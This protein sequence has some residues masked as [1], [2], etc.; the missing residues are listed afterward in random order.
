MTRI[1]G[2]AAI[3]DRFDGLILDQFGVLHDGARAYPD[4]AGCVERLVK[5]G[6]SLVLLS[7]SGRRTRENRARL[8]ALG[9]PVAAFAAVVTSGEVVWETLATRADLFH[10]ALGRRCYLIAE[11]GEALFLAGLDLDPVGTVAD[12][13]F[14][15]LLGID[16]PRRS[17]ADYRPALAAGV[18][19]GIPLLCANSDLVRLTRSGL[20]PASGA[21]A[22]KYAAMGGYVRWYGKPEAAIYERCLAA[23]PGIDRRRVL[24]VGDSLEHDIDGAHAAGLASLYIRGGIDQGKPTALLP[25][26]RLLKDAAPDFVAERFRW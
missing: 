20:Q 24:A 25:D 10:A 6:K 22:Q 21:L 1:D 4:A 9:F 23:L 8:A 11:S 5:A 19:R 14:I 15:L 2:L 3:A 16:T 12:A 17:L 13:D 18:R 7:N 26:T